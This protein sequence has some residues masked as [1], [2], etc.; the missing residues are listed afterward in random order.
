M[1][2]AGAT[3]AP[4]PRCSLCALTVPAGEPVVFTNGEVVHA[5]CADGLARVT[6]RVADLVERGSGRPRCHTC[7]VAALGIAFDDLR[8]ATARLRLRSGFAV[9]V[10]NCSSC[11]ALRVT[12]GAAE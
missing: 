7:L 9:R 11:G 8:R 2:E 12:V 5:R 10:A 3:N 1:A 6:A 4:D